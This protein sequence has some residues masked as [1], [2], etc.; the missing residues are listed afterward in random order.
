MAAKKP[1]AK[2]IIVPPWAKP[3]TLVWVEVRDKADKEPIEFLSGTLDS[4][5]DKQMAKIHFDIPQTYDKVR[6]D[7]LMEKNPDPRIIDDL[8]NIDPLNDAEILQLLRMRYEKNMIYV[9]C[10]PTM[11]MT[12]PYKDIRSMLTKEIQ[13]HY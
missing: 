7:R 2:P 1:E 4:I 13:A 10:G 6:G 3:S 8:C 11:I 12:N 9:N 5:D